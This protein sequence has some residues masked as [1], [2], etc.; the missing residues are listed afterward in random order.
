MSESQTTDAGEHIAREIVEVQENSYGA[1]ARSVRVQLMDDM[2]LVVIDTELTLAEQTLV[3]AG[4]A[5]VVKEMREAYQSAI[6][7][8]FKA[9]IERHTGRRVASFLS[10]MS[11][12]DPVYS[13]EFFRLT[14]AA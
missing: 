6:A 12:D 1:G 14:P 9:I 7:P 11:M 4:S 8:T 13:V 5:K 3:D 2:V 10:A